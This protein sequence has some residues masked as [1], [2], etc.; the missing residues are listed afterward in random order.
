VEAALRL[1]R[2]LHQHHLLVR[3]PMDW[4]LAV[5]QLNALGCGPVE[6]ETSVSLGSILRKVA[7]LTAMEPT[8]VTLGTACSVMALKSRVKQI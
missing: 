5:Q 1:L 6:L 8:K 2:T 7:T 3:V 4:T